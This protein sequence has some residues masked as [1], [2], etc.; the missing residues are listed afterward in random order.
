MA[1]IIYKHTLL[2]DCLHKGWSYI[3]QTCKADPNERWR[4]GRGYII[5]NTLFAK[6]IKKY[7]INNWDIVWSHEI[8][9]ENIPTL[10]LAN[11]RE[12]YWIAYYHTCIYDQTPN[13]YNLT[14]GGEGS[15]GYKHTKETKQKIKQR[16]M[17]VFPNGRVSPMK[18]KHHS[19]ETKKKLGEDNKLHP[20]KYWLNKHRDENTKQKIREKRA[21]QIISPESYQKALETRHKNNN[22]GNRHIYQIDK[23]TGNIIKEWKSLSLAA[24]ELNLK[25]GN[26]CKVCQGL[27]KS[28]GGY[29]WKYVM[30]ENNE[31]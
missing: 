11:E 24:N 20:R 1:W 31:N 26:I 15:I 3:G 2:I 14:F 19:E 12:R 4:N 16:L 28:A 8:L 10:E 18:G 13:G 9:E 27:R 30:E 29:I 23:D 6:A 5:K 7:G 17:E 22:M 25:V 21:L